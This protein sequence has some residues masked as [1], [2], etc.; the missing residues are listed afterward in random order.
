MYISISDLDISPPQPSSWE[1]YTETSKQ[2]LF[3]FVFFLCNVFRIELWCVILVSQICQ[4]HLNLTW[5]DLY[6][7]IFLINIKVC[8][9]KCVTVV[10]SQT[11]QVPKRARRCEWTTWGYFFPVSLGASRPLVCDYNFLPSL[12]TK[13]SWM[14][15]SLSDL[16]LSSFWK[17]KL[18]LT[19]KV[20]CSLSTLRFA[21]GLQY[22]NVISYEHYAHFA[23]NART[24]N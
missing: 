22:G 23:H 16:E 4:W 18:L 14:K 24:A 2:H 10:E 19:T 21:Y 6:Y 8:L 9:F 15:I 1:R 17:W 13:F 5:L 3:S 7:K 11:E 12:P 20:F